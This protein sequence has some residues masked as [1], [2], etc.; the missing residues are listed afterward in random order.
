MN[1]MKW[2]PQLTEKDILDFWK[3][4]DKNILDKVEVIIVDNFA[5]VY[6][7][8]LGWNQSNQS[9]Q[10]DCGTKTKYELGDYYLDFC[11]IYASEEEMQKYNY[12][13]ILFMAKRFGFLYIADVLAYYTFSNNEDWLSILKN[14]K[15]N[16]D[17]SDLSKYKLCYADSNT[18]YFTDDFEN[19]WGDD[20]DDAPYEHNA[21][22][23]YEKDDELDTYVHHTHIRCISYLPEF[24]FKLPCDGYANSPYSVEDINKGAIPWLYSDKVGGL[25]GGATMQEAIDW[26]TKIGVKWAE[27]TIHE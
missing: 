27:L 6:V 8:E 9:N 12:S 7:W 17:T 11:D 4:Q 13:Y 24:Y 26:L 25:M 14:I 1:S 15:S 3:T 18:L 20:W 16:N 23:P 22:L 19:V 10:K 5:Y 2:F 21:G